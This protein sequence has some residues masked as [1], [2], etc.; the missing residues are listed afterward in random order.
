MTTRQVLTFAAGFV[1]AC[2]SITLGALL[3]GLNGG[4]R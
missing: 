1:S 3:R 2:L 4:Y